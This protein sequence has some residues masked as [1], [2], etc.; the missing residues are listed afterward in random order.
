MIT[1]AFP[2]NALAESNDMK[3]YR[4]WTKKT[5]APMFMWIYFHQPMEPALIQ[6]WKCFS[7]RHGSPDGRILAN[8]HSRWPARNLCLW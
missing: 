8:I 5:S 7:S 3:I 2:V 6:G 4:E 1:C